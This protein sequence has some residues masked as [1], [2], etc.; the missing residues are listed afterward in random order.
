MKFCPQRILS[1]SLL[2]FPFCLAIYGSCHPAMKASI[3]SY[4]LPKSLV[5]RNIQKASEPLIQK[6]ALQKYYLSWD[7]YIPLDD[8]VISDE[9]MIDHSLLKVLKSSCGVGRVFVWVPLRFHIPILGEKV[10]ECCVAVT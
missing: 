6:R 10:L 2:F 1:R 7:V 5:F 3:A 9:R 8:I 4:F